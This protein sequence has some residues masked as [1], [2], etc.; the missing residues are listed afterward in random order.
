VLAL[1]VA[2]IFDVPKFLQNQDVFIDFDN[3]K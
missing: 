2:K 3:K 1:Q